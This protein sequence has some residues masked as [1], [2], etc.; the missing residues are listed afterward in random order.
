MFSVHESS[1]LFS[2]HSYQAQSTLKCPLFEHL[3]GQGFFYCSIYFEMSFYKYVL[4][5]L[6]EQVYAV[7]RLAAMSHFDFKAQEDVYFQVQV[8]RRDTK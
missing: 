2:K 3:L 4:S 5:R 8:S 7:F 6:L 1:C